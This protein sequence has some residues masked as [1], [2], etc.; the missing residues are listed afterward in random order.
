[1]NSRIVNAL[2]ALAVKVKGSGAVADI[3]ADNVVSAIEAV[4]EEYLGGSFAPASTSA[5]GG[6]KAAAASDG[7]TVEAKIRADGK[8]YVPTYPEIPA[9][10]IA[11]NQ[12]ASTAGDVAGL[13]SDFNALLI[14]LKAAG[15]MAA[16]S[17][18]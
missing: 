6:V 14:K 11:A 13:L 16:D 1:M 5:Y 7:D 2:K 4:T 10:P 15:L 17:G 9:I 12:A 8:L 3:T 18:E